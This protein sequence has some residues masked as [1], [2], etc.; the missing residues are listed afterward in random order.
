MYFFIA[1]CKRPQVESAQILLDL[2]YPEEGLVTIHQDPYEAAKNTHA[3]VVCTEW[4]EFT[5]F[6][7]SLQF[8]HSLCI[9]IVL[10]VHRKKTKTRTTK[11]SYYN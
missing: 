6:I 7:S 2:N 4:D 10:L 11:C 9:R 3:L 8:P 5:V 1:V